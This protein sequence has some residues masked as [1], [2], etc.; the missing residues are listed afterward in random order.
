M[1]ALAQSIEEINLFKK[2][3]SKLPTILALNLEV[4]THC[5]IN[6][7]NFI[8][9]FEGKKYHNITEKIILKSKEFLEQIDF[10]PLKYEFLKNDLKALLRYKFNQTS[11][12]IEILNIIK[13]DYGEIIYTNLH[14]SS[15]FFEEEREYINLEEIIKITKFKNIKKIDTGI[16]SI[17]NDFSYEYRIN[18]LKLSKKKKIIFNNA[19]Y[20]FK[21]IIYFL[22]KHKK[23]IALPKKNLSIVKII[24]FRL[25]GIELYEFVKNKKVEQRI[26]LPIIKDDLKYDHYKIS[27]IINNQVK[28]AKNY[29]NDLYQKYKSIKPYFE[30]SY[31]ELVLTNTNRDIGSILIEAASETKTK[32][33]TISHGT[34][35]KSYDKLDDIYKKYIAEGVFL[36]NSEIKA[37]QTKICKKSLETLNTSGNLVETGNLIFAERDN[38]INKKKSKI[39]YAVTNKRLPALQIHGVE[40]FFEF[41]RNLKALNTFCKNNEIKVLVH[42]HPGAKKNIRKFKKIFR[43]LEFST[44]DIT[45]SLKKSFVTLSFSSTVIE[46]SLNYLV[47]VIL[48]DLNKKNYIHFKAELSPSKHDKALYYIDNIDNLDKCIKTIK[49]SK[50]INFEEYIYMRKSKENIKFFFKN[51]L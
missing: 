27:Q 31:F 46:D 15:K 32:S 49:H 45:K 35:S 19:G 1:L 23:K 48:L 43:F 40:Y 20:N 25:L 2:N 50:N 36:S 17:S 6:R 39:L 38:F 29:L 30:K 16:K 12:V 18:G 5:E 28:N 8:V 13:D 21:R 47:P 9:P 37:V 3:F 24:L 41:Y 34:I 51:Y 7:L 22:I 10:S 4:I 26:E 44:G 11:F 14:S 33:I 42:L